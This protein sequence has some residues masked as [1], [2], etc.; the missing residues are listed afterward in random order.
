MV[1]SYVHFLLYERYNNLSDVMGFDERDVTPLLEHWSNVSLAA[2][3]L[4]R[5]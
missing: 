4:I 3:P 1:G 2:K 5:T